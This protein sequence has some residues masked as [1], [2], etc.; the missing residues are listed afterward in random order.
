MIGHSSGEIAA[1]AAAG[2][3]TNE[4]AIRVA[5]YRGKAALDLNG[6]SDTPLGM[7]AVGL[8]QDNIQRYLHNNDSIEVAC[9]NSPK[10]VTVSGKLTRLNE[11][12]SVIQVDGHFARVLQVDLAYH[13]SYMGDIAT[14]YQDLLQLHCELDTPTRNNIRMFSTVT[15]KRMTGRCDN[16]YWRSNMVLPVLFDEAFRG[17]ISE[18]N[19]PDFLIEIGPSGALAGPVAQIKH[20]MSG[21]AASFDYASAFKRDPDPTEELYHL[22][23]KIFVRGGSINM[24]QVNKDEDS[25]SASVIIDLPNYAWNHSVQYWHESESSKDWRSREFVQHDLLGSKIL[26]TSWTAP[27][28]R[29]TLRVTELP[30][31]K[32]HKVCQG[33]SLQTG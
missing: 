31:L 10:S 5:Y 27:S 20:E 21:R 2:F 4:A 18:P 24:S 32:D 11:L 7:L 9:V 30:W 25:N 16:N 14:H 33:I 6:G 23:G 12:Q 28:W 26:G 3:L 19:G 1:A 22:A 29:K 8:G 13:S 17:M 15:G